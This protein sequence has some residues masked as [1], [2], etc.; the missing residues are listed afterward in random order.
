MAPWAQIALL[1]AASPADGETGSTAGP[2]GSAD[3]AGAVGGA[4]S[5]AEAMDVA[6]V[7][8]SSV[9]SMSDAPT[10]RG[11]QMPSA[12]RPDPTGPLWEL[13]FS[14]DG[15]RLATVDINDQRLIIWN[16]SDARVLLWARHDKKL[17]DVVWLADDIVL[18]ADIDTG[19]T[20]WDIVDDG[21]SWPLN[22]TNRMTGS[23][24]GNFTGGRPGHLWGIDV[25]DDGQ[26]VA[27]CGDINEPSIG[28]EIVIVDVDHFRTGAATN[29]ASVFSD[30]MTIDCAF[31]PNGTMIIGIERRWDEGQNGNRD[32]VVGWWL[33]NMSRLWT[34]NVGGSLATAWAV[35]WQPDGSAYTVVWNRP[36]EGVVSHFETGDGSVR[37]FLP[38]PHN[39][40]S[41][42]WIADMT[43]IVVGTHDPGRSIILDGTG[44]VLDD[45]GWHSVPWGGIG[46]PSDVLAVAV[47]PL[48]RLFASAGRDGTVEIWQFYDGG[49]QRFLR[50][51]GSSLVREIDAHPELPLIVT[52]DAGGVISVWDVNRGTLESQCAHPG[53]GTPID[54]VPYAKSVSFTADGDYLA[55][56]SDGLIMRCEMHGKPVWS[57]DL[58]D[59]GNIEVF[60]RLAPH[61]FDRW[62]AV[63]WG[64]DPANST[65]D[66]V[67]AVIDPLTGSIAQQ[68]NYPEVHWTLAWSPD[69]SH[70]SSVSQ[71]G[72]VRLWATSDPAPQ[73]WTEEATPYSHDNYTSV[74]TWHSEA[75]LLMTGGWDRSLKVYDPV[76]QSLLFN[77]TASGEIFGAVFVSGGSR[78]AIASGEAS[79]SAE[80]WIEIIDASNQTVLGRYPVDAIPRGI[81]ELARGEGLV[82]TNHTGSWQVLLPDL[83]GDGVMDGVDAFPDD[84]SQSSDRDDDGFGDR[85]EGYHA[86]ACPDLSG[87]SDEDRYGCP[88]SDSDGFSDPDAA[89]PAHPDGLADAFVNDSMQHWDTDRDGHGDSYS[90]TLDGVGLR[91]QTGDSFILDAEQW[92]DR[93][94]DGCGDNHFFDLGAD[95]L[96]LNE[97][98]DA[99][100]DD[101]SQCVDR[102]G[103]GYGDAYFATL[104]SDGLLVEKGDLFPADVLAW[105]DPDGDGCV[106]QSATGLPLDLDSTD[107]NR[108]DEALSFSLP[109]DLSLV[110]SQAAAQWRISISW[111]GADEHSLGLRLYVVQYDGT[112]PSGSVSGAIGSTE[113]YANMT[114]LENWIT[115][116]ATDLEIPLNRSGAASTLTVVLVADSTEQQT[117]ERWWN[118]TWVEGGQTGTGGDGGG[119]DS[120]GDGSGGG[121]SGGQSG[122]EDN[123]AGGAGSRSILLAIVLGV[124]VLAGL[125]LVLIRRSAG[126]AVTGTGD[127]AEMFGGGSP[128]TA[129]ALYS[130]STA[131]AEP[132]AACPTCGGAASA[133]VHN[134]ARWSWCPACRAWLTYLGP[135]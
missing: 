42:R 36:T 10:P 127:V 126:D 107:S 43:R 40:S 92:S 3:S 132:L 115:D 9:W 65:A 91:N 83:D 87:D 71:S 53:F 97:T 25:S 85:P 58:N 1:P 11:G 15:T 116:D 70:L 133:T 4:G 135:E 129:G 34:R 89:W 47:E 49:E 19:W 62:V 69:A 81:T 28:G 30:K 37:W 14:P 114:L 35:D 120:N 104:G 48:N 38:F 111:T 74:N 59:L 60:G 88:D 109:D 27:F 31:S 64:E 73:S 82:I 130:D 93:D 100:P 134:G 5:L 61:P 44:V 77:A 94:G 13:D 55:G 2:T 54:D 119:G 95:G 86:D 33:E 122:S 105:W 12:W 26:R 125:G 52:A 72:V 117:L 108:C 51:L 76:Q 112:A 24:S 128:G 66:G 80:G 131:P 110:V 96:R 79:T 78:I 21:G 113:R 68:W 103:D 8:G 6:A 67:V 41:V 7:S 22:Q 121:G 20:A 63:S 18:T 56:F 118:A 39:M 75:G 16:V 17:V 124:V 90:F 102:D 84:A 98:G 50:R 99:F 32:V 23:W 101:A 123:Q 57:L 46:Q 106:P 29:A 45:V